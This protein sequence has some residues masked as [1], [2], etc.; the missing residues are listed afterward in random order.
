M[1]VQLFVG[2]FLC[3]LNSALSSEI[4]A[5]TGKEVLIPC[6]IQP[7]DCG[8]YKSVSWYNGTSEIYSYEAKA[9]TK[10]SDESIIERSEVVVSEKEV[11]LK[12]SS[13]SSSDDGTYSC[14]VEYLAQFSGCDTEQTNT[15][16]I[17]DDVVGE[18]EGSVSLLCPVDVSECGRYH[19][20]QWYHGSSR[21]YMYSPIFGFNYP[22]GK[23][24]DR[25][26]DIS[27]AHLG[28][29]CPRGT[30]IAGQ[31]NVT[32]QISPLRH[33]DVGEYR[34]VVGYFANF[35]GCPEIH[36]TYVKV[37]APPTYSKMYSAEDPEDDLSGEIIGP[38]TSG[39]Q[40]ELVCETGGGKPEA[41][42]EWFWKDRPEVPLIWTTTEEVE[43]ENGSVTQQ[44]HLVIQIK[45]DDQGQ[46]LVCR[47]NHEALKEPLEE[48]I[49]I[50]VNAGVSSVTLED[51]SLTGTVGEEMTVVCIAGGSRLRADISWNIEGYENNTNFIQNDDFPV[52]GNGKINSVSKLTFIPTEDFNTRT[53]ICEA[54]NELMEEPFSRSATLNIQYIPRT[55]VFPS[56]ESVLESGS[57]TLYC[58]VEANP[59]HL[60]PVQWRLNGEMV[61]EGPE[62]DDQYKG[63]EWI[64][65]TGSISSK[66]TIEKLQPSQDGEY[67]CHTYN[68]VGDSV[69]TSAAYIDVLFPPLT[70]I[71]V[72][73]ET[74]I[75][76]EKSNV[77]LTCT[78][79]HGDPMKLLKVYWYLDSKLMKVCD[80]G[81]TGTL[82]EKVVENMYDEYSESEEESAESSEE[83]LPIEEIGSGEDH[84]FCHEDT[85]EVLTLLDPDRQLSGE[86]TCEGEN[87]AGQGKPSEPLLLEVQ[88]APGRAEIK[89][90]ETLPAK[91]DTVEMECVVED[92]GS[93][94]ATKYV[95]IRDEEHLSDTS[96]PALI[97]E[98]VGVEQG[99]MYTCQAINDIG[100]GEKGEY[101]LDITGTCLKVLFIR[102]K[103]F[104]MFD[105]FE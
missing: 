77:S 37:V 13:L 48:S 40:L 92:M 4:L 64:E 28:S 73:Q 76:E 54:I 12:I 25:C 83:Y 22:A 36:S 11:S 31:Y 2:C 81:N 47:I 7:E 53:I 26:F 60:G 21:I 6:Q 85:V 89:V 101:H 96:D 3:I 50:Q 55:E 32:L 35:G 100:A 88:Y 104:G 56:Y 57:V 61:H 98:G 19:S 49:E 27:Q 103:L 58:E 38:L 46:A 80:S 1:G 30:L 70:A 90:I 82:I 52:L 8:T 84:I 24:M 67:T 17:V 15:L 65:A 34:C 51:G 45:D 62:E 86:W 63:S 43:D 66:L 99:G 23:L 42:I 72:S 78:M 5:F 33:D 16:R 10:F 68:D 91:K 18:E 97:L 93:P 74:V 20:V 75:E 79:L 44:S 94:R 41:E 59:T 102:G 71:S 87:S 95:W 14:S 9:G 105:C 39:I 29:E 69:V